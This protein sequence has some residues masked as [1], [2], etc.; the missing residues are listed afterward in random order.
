MPTYFT[1]LVMTDNC[2]EEV[3]VEVDLIYLID[4]TQIFSPN[5]D[6]LNETWYIDDI[7][8]YPN[9]DVTV[10]NRWGSVVY[11]TQ[12]YQNDWPGTW[13]NGEPL[14]VAT[15]YF[16]IDLKRAGTEVVTGSVTI[17]R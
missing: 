14:P 13:Q 7:E 4:P 5:G 8:E 10:F 12:Q 11:Q 17:V 6:G 2:M 3:D 9:A 16:V 1:A 15:Y